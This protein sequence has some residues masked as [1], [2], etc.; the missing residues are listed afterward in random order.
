M[1]PDGH[2][3][4]L[5]NVHNNLLWNCGIRLGSFWLVHIYIMHDE[6]P[7]SK[8]TSLDH[9]IKR[10]PYWIW[11]MPLCSPT[12]WIL[13]WPFNKCCLWKSSLI[14]KT[15]LMYWFCMIV[16]K[17]DYGFLKINVVLPIQGLPSAS[18]RFRTRGRNEKA[19]L[20]RQNLG[21]WV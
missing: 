3:T 13:Q 17:D 6:T 19:V 10:S 11:S 14:G 18:I 15:E 4:T 1:S 2:V 20:W 12:M 16:L 8:A 7:T 5:Y 21:Y 9:V